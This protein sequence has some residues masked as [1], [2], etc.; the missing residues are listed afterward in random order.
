MITLLLHMLRLLPFVC[1]GHRLLA[2]EN[3]AL[4]QQLTVYKRRATRPP[5][6]HDGSSFLGRAGQGLDRVETIPSDRDPRH[7]PAARQRRRFREHWTK[8]SGR[9]TGGRPPINAEIDKLITRMAAANPLWGAPRIHGEL[10]KLGIHV[11]ERTVSRLLPKRHTPPCSSRRPSH[12]PRI[13]SGPS[14]AAFIID[15]ATGVRWRRT[16]RMWWLSGSSIGSEG[17]RPS[18]PRSP[19]RASAIQAW[20]AVAWRRSGERPVRTRSSPESSTRSLR[21]QA[22]DLVPVNRDLRGPHPASSTTSST[23]RAW[24]ARWF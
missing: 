6:P 8:L 5:A 1:G 20:P 3:L 10:L 16:P 24:I 18:A 13:R 17:L 14:W 2:I 4:R 22:D 9:P 19:P 15:P 23:R 21:L 12:C 7:R 11:A